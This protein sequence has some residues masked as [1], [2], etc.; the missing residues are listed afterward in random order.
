MSLL[1]QLALAVADQWSPAAPCFTVVPRPI[2][3]EPRRALTTA[4][5]GGA[6]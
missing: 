3:V 5:R 2:G 6:E 1:Q 4:Y